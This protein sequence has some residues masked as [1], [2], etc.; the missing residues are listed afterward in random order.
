M[1]KVKVNEKSRKV[2]VSYKSRGT[3][4]GC[5]V[6]AS[7]IFSAKVSIFSIETWQKTPFEMFYKLNSSVPAMRTE[8]FIWLFKEKT[9]LIHKLRLNLKG[10]MFLLSTLKKKNKQ[11]S[12][13]KNTAATSFPLPHSRSGYFIPLE[14][15]PR[16]SP[17]AIA[18]GETRNS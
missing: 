4:S 15:I 12:W 5:S 16:E 18:L 9:S 8:Y 7:W 1:L 6:S 13:W 2:Q 14:C 17:R 11:K 3:Y 10:E